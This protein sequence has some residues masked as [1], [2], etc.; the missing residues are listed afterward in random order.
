MRTFRVVCAWLGDFSHM[1]IARQVGVCSRRREENEVDSAENVGGPDP[2]ALL[3]F[4][5][6]AVMVYAGEGKMSLMW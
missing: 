2:Q 4:P 5:V 6:F 1:G 3:V